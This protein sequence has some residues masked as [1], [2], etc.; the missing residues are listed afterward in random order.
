MYK[1][2]IILS[3]LVVTFAFF[4][5]AQSLYETKNIGLKIFLVL[6]ICFM[7]FFAVLFMDMEDASTGK[8]ISRFIRIKIYT[9]YFKSLSMI[10]MLEISDCK[11]VLLEKSTILQFISEFRNVID[12]RVIQ[13]YKIE[14]SI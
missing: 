2:L 9:E 4:V 3:Y 8:S 13:L 12:Y 11:I 10:V 6:P 7:M 1:I 5:K 14:H